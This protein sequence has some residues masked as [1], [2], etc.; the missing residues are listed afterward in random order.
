MAEPFHPRPN[1]VGI[2]PPLGDSSSRYATTAFVQSAA[3]G[4]V[5]SVG[6]TDYSILTTD[7]VING[8]VPFTSPRT[9]TF[10]AV[11]SVNPG[12]V[13]KFFPS[14][15][16]PTNTLTLARTGAD[17]FYDVQTATI[18]T[19]IVLTNSI[20]GFDAIAI[21]QGGGSTFWFIVYFAYPQ[22]ITYTP[23]VTSQ[24]GTITSYTASG[25]FIQIGS[26]VHFSA[27]VTITNQG[28]ATGF[29]DVTLPLTS[30]NN[31]AFSG[32]IANTGGGCFAVASAATATVVVLRADATSVLS[33]GNTIYLSGTYEAA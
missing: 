24:G 13:I 28:T 15:L 23:T 4:G 14:T 26:I 5:T 19:S 30:L 32:G 8:T 7:R 17:Q 18:T 31:A 11:T 10:P 16:T 1:R 20:T 2:T 33:S 6:D 27:T 12:T 9:W 22:W 21:N 25:K 29:M 3:A